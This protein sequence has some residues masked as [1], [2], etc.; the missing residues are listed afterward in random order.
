MILRAIAVWCFV[1][2]I[3]IFGFAQEC[4]I[5]YVSP[6]GSG[7][8]TKTAPTSIQNALSLVGSGVD[9][10]RMAQGT[11]PI[12][13]TLNLV[14]GV[15]IDGGYD[16]TTW[17]K[18]NN[19]PTL[20]HRDDVAPTSVSIFAMA[21]ENISDFHLHDIS[22]LVDDAVEISSSACGIY[23]NGCSDYS[24]DRVKITAGN[25]ADGIQGDPG[26]PGLSG[27]DGM[28]GD[29]G[30]SCGTGAARQGGPGGNGWS[31]GIAAG[32]AGGDG[33]EEGDGLQPFQNAD[34]NDG[35]DGAAGAGPAPG[36]GRGGSPGAPP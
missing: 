29:N 36:T 13:D 17:V 30:A 3:P 22:I 14:S 35:Y 10:I 26:I 20:I 6:N 31:G 7:S 33:G 4:D 8:G 34:G 21:A 19:T 27:A 32:G 24:L 16:P 9:Q 25:G 12:S 5:I 18:C 15:T 23:I 2:A 28:D 1:L 11:Y